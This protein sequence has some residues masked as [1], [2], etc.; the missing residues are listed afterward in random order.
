MIQNYLD[1]STAHLTADTM[2]TNKPHLFLV[3]DYEEGA[4]YWVPPYDFDDWASCPDDLRTV[5]HFAR[6]VGV[7]LVRVDADAPT[8]DH[9]P[10]YDWVE[11]L[12]L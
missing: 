2:I 4:F 6:S 7:T 9:L 1:I 12:I 5:L 8:T 10:K 11:S 3:A